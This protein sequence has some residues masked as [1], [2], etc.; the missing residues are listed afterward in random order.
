MKKFLLSFL[1]LMLFCSVSIANCAENNQES[2]DKNDCDKK[3][4]CDQC[5]IEDDEYFIYNQCYF[6]K[7]FRKTKLALCLDSKQETRIDNI[8]KNFKSDLETT[9]NRYKNEKNKLLEMIACDDPCY[10]KQIKHI[11]HIK[12]D[13]KEKFNDYIDD[14]KEQLCPRQRSCFRKIEKAQKRKLKEIIKYGAI[15]KL[16]CVECCN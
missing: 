4:K 5:Q 7:Q 1:A 8:Y 6:D 14:I 15:Y 16:P 2:Y 9:F 11:K 3:E 12:K 13:I 10:K